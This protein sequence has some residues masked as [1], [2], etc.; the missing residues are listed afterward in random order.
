[1]DG[2]SNNRR[3]DLFGPAARVHLSANLQEVFDALSSDLG[4]ALALPHCGRF[5]DEPAL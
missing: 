2:V 5:C 1:M 3:P 4:V